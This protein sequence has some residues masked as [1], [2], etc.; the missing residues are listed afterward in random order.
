MY[1]DHRLSNCN[2]YV[3]NSKLIF[4]LKVYIEATK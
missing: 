4:I 3:K 1:V 2:T